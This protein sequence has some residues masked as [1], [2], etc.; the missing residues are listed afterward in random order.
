MQKN[1]IIHHKGSIEKA[2]HKLDQKLERIEKEVEVLSVTLGNAEVFRRNLDD[3]IRLKTLEKKMSEIDEN[4]MK[5]EE[6][7]ATMQRHLLTRQV[8]G[9]GDEAA[10][11]KMKQLNGLISTCRLLSESDFEGKLRSNKDKCQGSVI[12]HSETL[13]KRKLELSSAQFKDIDKV[14]GQQ[15][16][17]LETSEIAHKDLEKYYVALDKVCWSDE[18]ILTSC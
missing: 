5:L 9:A 4:V 17:V 10:I 8:K 6:K 18:V 12:T 16:V 2:Q 1:S 13:K 11:E 3:N 7:V 15:L 14:H